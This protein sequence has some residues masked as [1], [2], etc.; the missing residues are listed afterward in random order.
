MNLGLID[1][2]YLLINPIILGEGKALFKDLNSRHDL[3][4][5][6]TKTFSNGVALLHYQSEPKDT[7]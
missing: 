6:E 1:E 4:L 7:M 3:N 2:Y 5:M